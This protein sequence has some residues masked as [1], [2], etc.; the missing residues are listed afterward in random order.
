MVHLRHS[1]LNGEPTLSMANLSSRQ[2]G[3]MKTN[4]TRN[5][6]SL[7]YYSRSVYAMVGVIMTRWCITT[8]DGEVVGA[9]KVK[10]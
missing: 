10:I 1:S 8:P 5:E 3:G 4:C 9:Q 6:R 2:P 7:T